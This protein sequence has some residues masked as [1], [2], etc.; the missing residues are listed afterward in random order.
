MPGA[1]GLQALDELH[2]LG[3]R[4]KVIVVT[5]YLSSQL[6]EKCRDAGA[7]GYLVKSEDLYQLTTMIDRVL[8]GEK[9]FPDFSQHEAV[10]NGFSYFD[11]FLKRSEE[12]TSELQS[13][14]RISYAVF[15]LKKQITH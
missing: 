9:V 1:D 6:V 7:S 15:C 4:L 8:A 2:R 12:H 10:Q 3:L 13:L 5:T 11:E 14:M